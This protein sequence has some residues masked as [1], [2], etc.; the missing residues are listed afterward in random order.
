M[1][2][3][4]DIDGKFLAVYGHNFGQNLFNTLSH[5]SE[6]EAACLFEPFDSITK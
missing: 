3:P 1:A 6:A 4:I 2:L 5:F